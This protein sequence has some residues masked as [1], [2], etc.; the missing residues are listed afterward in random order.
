[1]KRSSSALLLAGSLTLT[2]V[3]HF[4]LPRPFDSIVPRRLPGS[5]RTWTYLSGAAELGCAAAVT[6]PRSR[7][8]GAT[9]TTA[10]FVAVFPAN[11]KM[12]LDYRD[13]SIPLR[14]VAYAR[15]PLQLPLIQWSLRV[16]R[17]T[18]R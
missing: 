7:R 16:R 14:F 17:N 4:L 2:G 6:H 18:G 1:M 8:V 12:A 3:L 13:R 15:L 11:I 5:S 10:L 9:V